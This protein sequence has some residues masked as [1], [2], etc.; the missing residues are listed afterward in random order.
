[1][2]GRLRMSVKECI[3]RYETLIGEV[4]PNS[5]WKRAGNWALHGEWY[6][7]SNL[8]RVIKDLIREKL[9][10]SEV[11]LLD[12][13]ETNPCK[14]Y[15]AADISPSLSANLIHPVS[16]LPSTSMRETIVRLSSFDRTTTRNKFPNCPESSCG[17]LHAQHPPRPRTLSQSV[18]TST[19]RERMESCTNT[20]HTGL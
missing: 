1:M 12:K 11:R 3:K 13:D 16:S 19:K 18:L 9:G 7:A 14:V 5:S 8:E 15:E 4:F 17:K 2:L 6:D 20:V 10:D